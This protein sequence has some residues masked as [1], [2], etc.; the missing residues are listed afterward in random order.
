MTLSTIIVLFFFW[1]KLGFLMGIV[2]AGTGFFLIYLNPLIINIVYFRNKHP[3]YYILDQ[4]LLIIHADPRDSHINAI[5]KIV[6]MNS[7]HESFRNNISIEK[8]PYN[9]WRD[10]AFI[11]LNVML[12]FF[13]LFTLIVQF[14]EINYFGIYYKTS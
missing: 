5:N 11:T 14:F 4:Q 10:L 8:K 7:M 9:K 13:G 6:N 1:N 3:K 12:I 2:G